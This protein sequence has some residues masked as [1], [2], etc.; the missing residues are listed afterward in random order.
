MARDLSVKDILSNVKIGK[1][2]PFRSLEESLWSDIPFFISTGAPSLDFAIGGYR[3]GI[4]GGIPMG[5]YVEIF[6]HESSGKSVLLDHIFKNALNGTVIVDNMLVNREDLES[7]GIMGDREHAHDERRMLEL[8]VDPTN[9][10]FIE[11]SHDEEDERPKKGKKD[12]SIVNDFCLEDFFE[13]GEASFSEIRKVDIE[14]PIIMA[15]DSLAVTPTRQQNTIGFDDD[16]N[17]KDKLDKA[18][19]MSN[20]FPSFCSAI[21]TKNAALI[22][23]NQI[24]VR[25]NI[26]FGNPEY[27]PGGETQKFLATLRIKLHSQG[28]IKPPDDPTREHNGPD[29]VGIKVGFEIVKN[30]LAP[31]YRKGS[32]P[33]FFD[34][35]G[36]F[37]EMCFAEMLIEREIDKY[38]PAFE[39]SGAWYSWKG[40]RIGQGLKNMVLCFVDSPHI[41]QEMENE[42]FMGLEE[43]ESEVKGMKEDDDDK[44]KKAKL[45]EM[46]KRDE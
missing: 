32:F 38:F 23:V 26:Q 18:T 27:S 42:I 31:P 10:V 4:R 11:L 1:K 14:T 20:R 13:I 44:P 37:Y 34:D 30:K 22:F 9:L 29:P 21:T 35:R 40:E 12:D 46:L 3:R 36:I 33:L 15:L 2:S 8:G 7:I 39:K 17:M 25:P 5:R 45:S 6:G 41:M 19:I 28:L 16:M 43:G 24:R